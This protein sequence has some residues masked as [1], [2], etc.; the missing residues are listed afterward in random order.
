[1]SQRAEKVAGEL[2]EVLGELV[3]RG[4]IKDPRVRDAGLVTITYVRMT[5]DLRQARVFFTV[6]GA[7]DAAAEKVR[8]GL[9]SAAG[10]M[11]RQVGER[12]RLKVTPGLDFEVDR[13]LDQEARIELLLRE[14]AK[15][16]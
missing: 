3:V 2:R 1:M 11:R 12:L 10:F 13:V 4:A 9:Q 7:D 14:V 16:A 8:V 15:K 6:H 5:G